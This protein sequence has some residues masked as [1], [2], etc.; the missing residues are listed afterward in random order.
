MPRKA[1]KISTRWIRETR[2]AFRDFLDETDF[3]DPERLGERGPKF[4]YPEWLIMFI[5]ILSV[6]L[7]VKS[8]VQI[9]KMAVQYWDII[10]QG[11]DLTPISEKQLRDRLKKIRHFPGDPAAFIFQLFPELE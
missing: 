9:H 8:Y 6:K 11:M 1:N 10:A 4:K 3:P 2:E 7:K 5:A